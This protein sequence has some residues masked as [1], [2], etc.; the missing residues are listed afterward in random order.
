MNEEHRTL[1]RAL[2]RRAFLGQCAAGAGSFALSSILGRHVMAAMDGTAASPTAKAK[3]VIMF[4]MSGGMS[5]HEL[6]DEKPLLNERRGEDFPAS[7]RKGK[8]STQFSEGQGALPVVGSIFPFKRYGSCGMNMSELLPNLGA[9]ADELTLVRSMQTDQVLHETASTILMTGT[10]LLGRP[11]W[12]SWV[13]YALGSANENLPE[14]CV[15]LTSAEFMA[16]IQQRLWHSGFLPGKYQGVRF[17]GSGDP[18]LF[19][20]NPPGV[21]AKMR[22]RV[23]KAVSKLNALEAETQ[24]VPDIEARLNAYE[25]A[26]RMQVSVPELADLSKESKETLERYGAVPGQSSLANNCLMARRLAERGVRFIQVCDGS[27]DLHYGIPQYM[28]YKA[29]QADRPIAALIADL[30]ERGLLDDTIVMVAGEFGRTP[31]SEGVLAYN[32][33]GRDHNGRVGSV[34]LA[35]GGFK[36]GFTYGK[37][38]EWGWDVAENPVHVN[39]LQATVL[40]CLGLDHEKLTYRHQG[41]DFRLTDV[42]GRVIRELLA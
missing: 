12:G 16:P 18:V 39:D 40:H 7:A 20:S 38:D 6:F 8:A 11:S 24:G 15:M 35:G 17:R 5:Q 41:R 31:F 32:N 3:R 23:L 28:P 1:H 26:A 4:F 30:K 22:D 42:G 10:P 14:F 34:L 2:C 36:R 19:L 13:S 29:K 21:D 27:W 33:Y 25:M 37:T 9:I